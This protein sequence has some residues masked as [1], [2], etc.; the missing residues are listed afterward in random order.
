[1]EYSVPKAG[2]HNHLA[3]DTALGTRYF[4]FTC[5]SKPFNLHLHS[6]FIYVYDQ[7]RLNRKADNPL[8]AKTLPHFK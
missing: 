5:T 4:T 8:G 6:S 1:M 7:P 3:Y 2:K